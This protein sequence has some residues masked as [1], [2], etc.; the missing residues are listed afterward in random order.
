MHI[1]LHLRKQQLSAQVKQYTTEFNIEKFLE[2]IPDPD[3]YFNDPNKKSSLIQ[4]SRIDVFSLH[5]ARSF[6]RN[7][8]PII[9]IKIINSIM[10][11][12]KDCLIP[13]VKELDAIVA[14][15]KGLM[16]TKRKSLSIDNSTLQNIPLLQEVFTCVYFFI[17]ILALFLF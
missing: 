17:C 6:L 14:T 3:T 2:L 15:K 7:Q 1:L 11:K 5:Y 4:S 8:Y 10:V 13:T 9:P 16:K 12:N